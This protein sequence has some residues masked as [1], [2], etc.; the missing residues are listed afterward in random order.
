MSAGIAPISRAT[1]ALRARP[2]KIAIFC[3]FSLDRSLLSVNS[4]RLV[5]MGQTKVDD[6]DATLTQLNRERKTKMTLVLA[7]IVLAGIAGLIFAQLSNTVPVG[8]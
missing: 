2:T 1:N 4:R 8:Y 3:G 6:I 5:Q 7:A